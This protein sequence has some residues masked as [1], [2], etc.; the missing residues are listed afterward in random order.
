V[1]V[2]EP[3]ARSRLLVRSDAGAAL[4]LADSAGL[5]D[6]V[7][8]SGGATVDA[9]TVVGGV[10]A[11]RG[12]FAALAP[13]QDAESRRAVLVLG[14]ADWETKFVM[15]A[16][17]ESGW[18]VRGRIPTAP[19]V[20]VRDEGLLPLDTA[21]YDAVIALDSS[22]TDLAP[23]IARFVAQGGGLIVGGDALS[24]DALRSLVPARAGDRK[25]GRIL[26]SDDTVTTRDLPMRALT[27]LRADALPLQWEAAGVTLAAR[28]AGLGR[29]L[30]VGYDESW[31]WRMLGGV[32]GLRQ[33]RRWWSGAVGSVASERSAG[34]T[35]GVDAAPLAA[36]VS[37]LG[38]A[39][40]LAAPKDSPTRDPLP[41]VIL[42]IIAV[43]L[44]AETASRRFRGVR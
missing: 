25:P 7:A 42:L 33:H 17:T 11:Q 10:R 31:R 37:A 12:A 20:V 35:Q 3:Q 44:L 1:R 6:S 9:A 32:S 4:A 5:I 14:R 36:L 22:A 21:R 8:A 16:L 38:P 2:R 26:L 41:L 18:V 19:G 29:V 23:A 24:T 30:A 34:A 40:S 13:A 28:R 39:S 27:S 15:Q 43:A